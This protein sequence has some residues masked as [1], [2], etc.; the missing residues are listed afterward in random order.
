MAKGVVTFEET[1]DKVLVTVRVSGLQP[2][3]E[4][5]FHVHEKGDCSAPDATSA[6]GHFNPDQ[7]PHAHP[8]QGKRHAG[9]MHNLKAD[10]KGQVDTT[11]EVDTVRLTEGKYRIVGRA[12]IIHAKPDDYVSQPVGNAGGRIACGVIVRS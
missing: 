12:L 6:G 10:A 9:A 5:G 4:H 8:G 7:Y 2:N 11:L 3:Q 1:P